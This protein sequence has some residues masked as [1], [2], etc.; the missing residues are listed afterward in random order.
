MPRP[1]SRRRVLTAGAFVF[2][3]LGCPTTSTSPMVVEPHPASP[4]ETARSDSATPTPEPIRVVADPPCLYADERWICAE[5]VSPLMTGPVWRW[6]AGNRWSCVLDEEGVRCADERGV[7]PV[8]WASAARD[9]AG[10]DGLCALIDDEVRCGG[11]RDERATTRFVLPDAERVTRADGWLC[12]HGA[13]AGRCQT[14][15]GREEVDFEGIDAVVGRCRLTEGLLRCS[16][17]LTLE[18]VVDL[19]T[20]DGVSCALR[21]DATVECWGDDNWGQ[22]GRSYA[23]GV[24]YRPAPVWGLTDVEQLH[25]GQQWACARTRS[26]ELRCWGN[27]SKSGT[28][29]V[30]SDPRLPPVDRFAGGGSCIDEPLA[31]VAQR[32]R[33]SASMDERIALLDRL[34][35]DPRDTT[36]D[37]VRDPWLMPDTVQRAEAREADLDGDGTPEWILE[38]VLT[39]GEPP[40][41]EHQRFMA[42][43]FRLA[44]DRRWC[45]LLTTELSASNNVVHRPAN[46][47]PRAPPM[48]EPIE[49]SFV[50]LTSTDRLAIRERRQD[51]YIHH[52]PFRS[53]YTTSFW[54]LDG[55]R[56]TRAFGPFAT[57]AEEHGNDWDNETTGTLRLRGKGVPKAIVTRTTRCEALDDDRSCDATKTTR[58][59]WQGETYQPR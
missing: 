24:S 12:A 30:A 21:D 26:N 23:T 20:V 16:G 32:L 14:E 33:K 37:Y 42:Q 2:A 19:Q 22:L 17:S 43:V 45:P 8:T 3:S 4:D 9:I 53:E 46:D 49:L 18:G 50:H 36:L 13:G 56:L 40:N 25:L 35:L 6:A 48:A 54:V 15:D 41:V 59:R 55:A 1:R 27:D 38:I 11:L 5:E 52:Y 47:H 28:R 51:G 10:G 58:W 57:Y 39:H 31:D 44:P 29:S 34:G 7:T